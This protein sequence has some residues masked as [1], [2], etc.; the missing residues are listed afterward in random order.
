MKSMDLTGLD[1][2]NRAVFFCSFGKDSS[3]VLH[4]I[5]PWLGKI[6]IVFI[7]CGAVY[8]DI[9][10][11]A[12]LHEFVLPRFLYLRTP[13]DIWESV[14]SR[15]WPVDVEIAHLGQFGAMMA[16]EPTAL[17][18][19]LRPYTECMAER[20]WSIMLAFTQAYQPDCMISGERRSDRP[21]ANDWQIRNNGTGKA[22]RPIFE[23]ND[24]DVWAYIDKHK[25]QLPK[26]YQGR[27]PDRRDCY[28]CMGGHDL[29]IQRFVELKRDWPE[30]Y[31]KVFVEEGF[32][33]IVPVMIRHLT[34]IR[35]KWAG[36]WD[37]IKE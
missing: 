19:K 10:E 5:R 2:I 4:G 22:I 20:F 21:A 35:D 7:D 16:Q 9:T 17:R 33:E 29:S 30:I 26:T 1:D 14:R 24:E 34:E 37:A 11:W 18:H 13:G 6:M 36:I 15:G 8:P 12:R 28:V 25:I 3:C 32:Q 23:W 27:Q 31:H